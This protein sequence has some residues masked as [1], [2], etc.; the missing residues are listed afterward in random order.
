VKT[1]SLAGSIGCVYVEGAGKGSSLASEEHR[2]WHTL[3][4]QVS[5]TRARSGLGINVLQAPPQ[6]SILFVVTMFSY[7]NKISL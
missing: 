1:I 6:V 4:T 3:T 5:P 2:C 7:V